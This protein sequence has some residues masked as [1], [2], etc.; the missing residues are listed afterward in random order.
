MEKN[1]D[2][3]DAAF[4]CCDQSLSLAPLAS[5]FR[6]RFVVAKIYILFCII[7]YMDSLPEDKFYPYAEETEKILACVF[8]VYHYFGPGFLESV[9]HKCLEI[10]LAKAEIPFESEKKLKIFYKGEDIGMKFSADLV[11]DNKIILE[12]KAKDRLKTE[13]EA[14]I[15]HYL[16]ISGYPLGLLINFGSK[17]K[18]EVRRF[19]NVYPPVNAD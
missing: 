4:G 18:A 9:Y 14:Q 6:S 13:D 10:E 7:R 1:T 11:I 5:C 19:I 3:T 2:R 17:R 16:K 15:L 12:L 8:D